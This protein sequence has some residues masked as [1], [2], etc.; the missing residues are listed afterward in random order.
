MK[1]LSLIS[2]FKHY[3]DEELG[4]K[5]YTIRKDT[6]RLRKLMK[7]K[8]HLQIQRAYTDK[9]FTRKITHTLF[10]EGWIIFAW[11]P[12]SRLNIKIKMEHLEEFN[13]DIPKR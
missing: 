12:T 2:T 3:D 7:D 5:P 4:I 10:W 13:T 6:P 8:D 9:H 1:P 11:N